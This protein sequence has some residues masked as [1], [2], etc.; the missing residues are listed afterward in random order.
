MTYKEAH[1]YLYNSLPVFQREGK[2]AYKEGMDN[3]Y[4]LDKYFNSPHS[5]YKTIHVA[6]TN[7]K[8]SVCH[9]LASVLQECGYVT[10]LYSSPHLLD[11]RERI[12]V[13]GEWITKDFITDFIQ[14]HKPKFNEMNPSFFEISVFMAFEYFRQQHVDIV[15][16]EVGLGGRLD[17]TNIINPVVSVI[18]N[19]GYDHM[20][21]LGNTIEQIAAEKAGIIK[22][23][24]PLVIGEYHNLSMPVFQ[25]V[26]EEK[27]IEL[28]CADKLYMY[29][30]ST[31]TLERKVK[32][33]YKDIHDKEF[34][35]FTD[36]QGS[37][38]KK[39]IVTALSVIEVIKRKEIQIE[40]ECI[41]NGLQ[42]VI[43]NTGLTGRWQII[44]NNP[45]VV[46]DTAHNEEGISEVLK[47][48]HETAYK[49]L[50]LVLGFV[51]DKDV[52]KM[53]SLFPEDASYYFT[54]A[55]VPRAME[56]KALKAVAARLNRG[57]NSYIDVTEAFD[58]AI[59]NAGHHDF[60]YIGGSTFVVADF[61]FKEKM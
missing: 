13:N 24:V 27:N 14:K 61:L 29:Q 51:K 56:H 16:I 11:Y 10:G 36:L 18:T 53:L 6:G 59:K 43:Q 26:A 8:G 52:E 4:E 2:A 58:A 41:K 20:E 15:I 32:H 60:I 1:E 37:Y 57:G 39:N 44:R 12:K 54:Q 40:D 22:Q 46:C 3:A 9:M 28:V 17:T 50:H 55:S 21:F 38:Q 34:D 35:I 47:Q 30:Y 19:I 5:N 33:H 49:K 42:H 31:H 7:G 48:I 23:N 45:T 25:R